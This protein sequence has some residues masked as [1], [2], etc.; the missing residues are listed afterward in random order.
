MSK[1]TNILTS[2]SDLLPEG[3]D[4]STLGQ[5]ANLVAKKIEEEVKLQMSDLTTKVTSFIR[6][7][8]EKLKEHAVKELELENETFRNSKLFETVRSMF[9]IETTNEDHLNGISNLAS[10][11]ESQEQKIDVLVGE[12]D[13]LLRENVQ[14]KKINKVLGGKNEKLEESVASLKENFKVASGKTQTKHMSDSAIIVSEQNF[15]LRDKEENK[16]EQKAKSNG[17]EWLNENII[18][19][20]KKLIKG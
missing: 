10:I 8:I 17:N 13:K 5:I 11:S 14:L 4:E 1:E 2:I 15:K 19:A 16:Q 20:S 3:L 18:S 12:V 6:G 9:A 7:N